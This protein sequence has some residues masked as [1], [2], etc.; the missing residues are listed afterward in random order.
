MHCDMLKIQDGV[1]IV[2]KLNSIFL[3]E[4]TN[5]FMPP[6][7]YTAPTMGNKLLTRAFVFVILQPYPVAARSDFKGT[8]GPW[9]K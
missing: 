8:K 7:M 4:Y 9:T 1:A 3:Y 5:G 2:E 6:L